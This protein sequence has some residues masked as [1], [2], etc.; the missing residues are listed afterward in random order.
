MV[1]LLTPVDETWFLEA[2]EKKW[3][4]LN[5]HVGLCYMIVLTLIKKNYENHAHLLH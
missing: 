1:A 2:K 3:F 4:S 5:I